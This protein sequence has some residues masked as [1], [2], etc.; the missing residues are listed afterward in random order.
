MND[1]AWSLVRPGGRLVFCTC[2]LLPDEGEVQGEE[3]L[4]RLS[5]AIAAPSELGWIDQNWITEEGGIRLRPDYWPDLGG[6][7]GFYVL[8]LDKSI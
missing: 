7:D 8:R 1:H 3:A 5:G 6:M 2:S 4:A